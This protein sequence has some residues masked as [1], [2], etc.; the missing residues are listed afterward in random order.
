[1]AVYLC[2]S[3]PGSRHYFIKTS[4]KH[5]AEM[6]KPQDE[7]SNRESSALHQVNPGFICQSGCNIA[8]ITQIETRVLCLSKTNDGY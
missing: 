4:H 6:R 5:A 3:F 2:Q 8:G 7:K 1:V